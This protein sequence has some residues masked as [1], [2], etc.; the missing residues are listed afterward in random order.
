MIYN[1][2]VKIK[3]MKY[4]KFIYFNYLHIILFIIY[5]IIIPESLKSQNIKIRIF[6][7]KNIKSATIKIN[8]GNYAIINAKD[9]LTKITSGESVTLTLK[10]GKIELKREE[11]TIGNY[12][13]MNFEG[14]SFRNSFRIFPDNQKTLQRTYDDH[15]NIEIIKS[16]LLFINNI[17]MENYIAGVVEAEA[18]GCSDNQ[19]FFKVQSV[20]S[21][22]YAVGHLNNHKVEGF[23]LC[24]AVHCQSYKGRATKTVLIKA[25]YATRGSVLADSNSKLITAAYHSNSGG[26]TVNSGDLWSKQLPYLI[27]KDDT[28]SINGKNYSWEIKMRTNEWLNFLKTNFN[29]PIQ[30]SLA[31]NYALNFSQDSSRLIFFNK[32]ITLRAIREKLKLRSTW[33]SVVINGDDIILKGR[34]YGHGVGLSQEGAIKMAENGFSY[35]DI[36]S[37]Y[38]NGVQIIKREKLF[39]N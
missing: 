39:V 24:D 9:T 29:Y 10:N 27:A 4:I 5:F 16:G 28:F 25:V 26:K 1:L 6:A 2:Y 8:T 31:I 15:L 30:D 21:R 36:I 34:G 33:F 38:Y 37:F 22:T 23:N 11:K 3:Q 32:E 20:I 17:D 7:D 14:L 35:T 13:N 19:E 18:G 12:N